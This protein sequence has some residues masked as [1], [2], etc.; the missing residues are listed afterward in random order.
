MASPFQLIVVGDPLCQPWATIPNV[1]VEGATAASTLKGTAILRPSGDSDGKPLDRFELFVNGV[2]AGR[3]A[4]AGTLEFDTTKFPDGDAELRIVGIESSA[5]ETQGRIILPVHIN[6]HDRSV[7]LSCSVTEKATWKEPFKLSAKAPDAVKIIFYEAMR[8]L[9]TAAG[10]HGEI[11]VKPEQMGLGP[12]AI[13]ARALYSE[14]PKDAAVSRPS[15]SHH[16]DDCS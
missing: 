5:I 4:T 14:D 6:N 3:C 1:S 8:T 2:Q 10:D 9:G 11:E 15:P 13:R 16:A 12:V 7:E